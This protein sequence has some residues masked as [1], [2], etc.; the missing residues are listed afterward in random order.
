MPDVSVRSTFIVGFPG[1]TEDQFEALLDFVDQAGFD[2]GGGFVYSPE[3]GTPAVALRPRVKAAV[4]Q[5]RLNRLTALLAERA[6]DRLGRLVGSQVTVMIDSLDPE[7]TGEGISAVGRTKGQAPEVDGV[8]YIEG[9]LPEGAGPGDEV[10]V[11][12]SAVAGYDLI[13]TVDAS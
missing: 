6:E 12:V 13:G 1:E 7:D 2:H 4:A 10:P 3:E 9:D 8:T 11:T 5:S